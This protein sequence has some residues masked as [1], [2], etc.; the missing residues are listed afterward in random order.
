MLSVKV[1]GIEQKTLQKLI[2]PLVITLLEIGT[3]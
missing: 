1:N 3:K 2:K